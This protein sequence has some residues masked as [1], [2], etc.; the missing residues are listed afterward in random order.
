[1]NFHFSGT[2]Q[3]PGSLR[4]LPFP[5]M[6]TWPISSHFPVP[7]SPVISWRPFPEGLQF[8]PN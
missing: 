3:E 2:S 4:G 7:N 5:S 8:H 6:S 1:M